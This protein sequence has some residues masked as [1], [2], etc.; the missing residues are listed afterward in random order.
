MRSSAIVSAADR[1]YDG[2]RRLAGI[3]LWVWCDVLA[4]AWGVLLI[5]LAWVR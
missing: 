3:L 2:K 5:V 1:E 4:I